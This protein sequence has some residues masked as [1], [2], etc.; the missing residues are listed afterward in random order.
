M[1]VVQASSTGTY[2]AYRVDVHCT[3]RAACSVHCTVYLKAELLQVMYVKSLT[4][5]GSW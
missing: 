5:A 2:I 1:V 4:V 3:V